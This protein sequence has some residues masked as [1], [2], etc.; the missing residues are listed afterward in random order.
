MEWECRRIKKICP[1]FRV[2]GWGGVGWT[3]NVEQSS[4]YAHPLGSWG[5]V[6]WGGGGMP[7]KTRRRLTQHNTFSL[8]SHTSAVLLCHKGP[9]TTCKYV[10][11]LEETILLT[12]ETSSTIPSKTPSSSHIDVHRRSTFDVHKR[13][14]VTCTDEALLTCT[15]E[16]RTGKGQQTVA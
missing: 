1:P 14:Q 16:P 8:W 4:R 10:I 12:K 11:Y 7:T 9:S 3:G 6:G 5:G 15:D 2:L 13:K